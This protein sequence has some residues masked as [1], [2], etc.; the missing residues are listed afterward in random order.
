M[1][2]SLRARITRLV[3]RRLLFGIP[4]V[5]VVS[6]VTFAL[7]AASPFDPLDAYLGGAGDGYTESERAVLRNTLGLDQPWIAAW[8][9]WITGVVTTG[10]L[11]HSRA[12]HEPL[13][14]VLADRLGWTACWV[15]RVRR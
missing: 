8:W 15:S 10:D 14:Q 5:V 3:V 4:L 11:G 2:G 13:A 7:A 1:T 9:H 6:L 12:Y